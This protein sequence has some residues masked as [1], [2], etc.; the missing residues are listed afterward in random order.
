MAQLTRYTAY[1]QR[2]GDTQYV[3]TMIDTGGEYMEAKE[4]LAAIAELEAEVERLRSMVA[5]KPLTEESLM[6]A[7]GGDCKD[8]INLWQDNHLQAVNYSPDRC[9]DIILPDDVRLMRRVGII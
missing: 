2:V 6:C 4:V 5:W 1:A 8:H 9:A 3:S 7:C